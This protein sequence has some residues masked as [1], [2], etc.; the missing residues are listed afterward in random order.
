MFTYDDDGDLVNTN[1]EVEAQQRHALMVL[2]SNK[3]DLEPAA[4]GQ[5]RELLGALDPELTQAEAERRVQRALAASGFTGMPFSVAV[6]ALDDDWR[7]K[8]D[9]R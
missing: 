8:I 5:L 1:D 3:Y 9:V 7:A 6:E 2:A 4:V